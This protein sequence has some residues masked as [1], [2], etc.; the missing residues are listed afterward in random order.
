VDTKNKSEHELVIQNNTL[1]KYIHETREDLKRIL[2]KA[3]NNNSSN[4]PLSS[5]K[6]SPTRKVSRVQDELNYNE[7]AIEALTKEAE[8]LAKTL[9]RATDIQ[10]FAEVD[11]KVEQ[12]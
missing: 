1:R 9:K 7:S 11:E 12:I 8:A 6:Y 4:D 2:N 5:R 10:Y 3:M